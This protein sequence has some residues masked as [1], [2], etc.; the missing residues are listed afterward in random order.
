MKL[1]GGTI[2]DAT[3]IAAPPSTKN[4]EQA[5]DPEM[6][7]SKKVQSVALWNEGTYGVDSQTGRGCNKFCVNGHLAGN[8]LTLRR[9]EHDR[10]TESTIARSY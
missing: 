10:N 6:C 1:S 7:Q 8:C 5:C 9:S 2:V 4:R 3:L